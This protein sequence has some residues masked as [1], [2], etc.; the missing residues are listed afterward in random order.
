MIFEALFLTA[1]MF[2]YSFTNFYQATVPQNVK[3]ISKDM[4]KDIYRIIVSVL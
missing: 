4:L 2:H 1:E 3:D